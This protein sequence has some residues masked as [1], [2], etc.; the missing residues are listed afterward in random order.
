MGNKNQSVLT[1]PRKPP[2]GAYLR[3]TAIGTKVEISFDEGLTWQQTRQQPSQKTTSP[4]RN[5]GTPS[6]AARKKSPFIKVRNIQRGGRANGLRK[7]YVCLHSRLKLPR[8]FLPHQMKSLVVRS[9]ASSNALVMNGQQLTQ[10]LRLIPLVI[11][12]KNRHK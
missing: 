1:F 10:R 11:V 6:Q 7:A 12:Y 4:P 9:L 5:F 8:Y 2:E 3:G